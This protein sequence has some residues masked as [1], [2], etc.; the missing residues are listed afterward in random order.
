MLNETFD[1]KEKQ[2]EY[3][4]KLL[5]KYHTSSQ[6]ICS[7]QVHEYFCYNALVKE[8]GK[9]ISIGAN[10]IYAL[11]IVWKLVIGVIFDGSF[12]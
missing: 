2:V 5:V 6:F 4:F 9:I 11:V 1:R 10:V 8:C 12:A 3:Y 7:R